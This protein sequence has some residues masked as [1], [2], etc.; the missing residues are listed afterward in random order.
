MLTNKILKIEG[1]NLHNLKLFNEIDAFNIYNYYLLACIIN[2]LPIDE[3]FAKDVEAYYDA[4]LEAYEIVPRW[5]DYETV[6]K[7]MLDC[8]KKLQQPIIL[9]MNLKLSKV[10]AQLE[11]IDAKVQNELKS[12]KTTLVPK[13]S[14]AEVVAIG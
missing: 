9:R 10:I 2:K 13:F 7:K 8:V 5:Q 6:H 11:D 4:Y 14:F 1:L 12:G 3:S